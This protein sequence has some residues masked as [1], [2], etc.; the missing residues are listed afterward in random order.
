MLD[1]TV[2]EFGRRYGPLIGFLTV[3]LLAALLV[4]ATHDK[5]S[6][7]S[8]A[9]ARVDATS[10]DTATTALAG[11]EA[12]LPGGA[13]LA[14]GGL[15]PGSASGARGGNSGVT[16][17]PVGSHAAA[18]AA[19]R[20]EDGRQPG[21]SRYMPPCVDVFRGDNGGATAKGV[22]RDKIIVVRYVN[23]GD[24]ATRAAAAA[25]STK[26]VPSQADWERET[27][28]LMRYFNLHY[29]TYR[30]EVV[31]VTV[32]ASGTDDKS[33]RAD[34]VKIAQEIG[35]F[36]VFPGTGGADV[37]AFVEELA[38]RHVFC[39][40]CT[41]GYSRSFYRR[42]KGYVFATAPPL[43]EI[44]AHVAEYIGKRLAGKPARW[45]GEQSLAQRPRRFGLLWI[46][47]TFP[48]GGAPEPGQK[49]ARDFLVAEL[50]RYGV[51]LTRDVGYSYDIS[52][53]QEQA[54]NLI[55]QMKTANVTTLAWHGDPLSLIVFTREATRQAYFP[56]W[57]IV[58]GFAS[59]S[60]IF[61]RLY[62]QAQWRHAFGVTSGWV[63]P[64]SEAGAPGYREYHHA[65]P[66]A[67]ASEG[68]KATVVLHPTLELLFTG[69]QMAGPRLTV[70]TFQKGMY[71]YPETGGLIVAPLRYF[72]PDS[73]MALKDATEVFYDAGRSGADEVGNQGV[74]VQVFAEGGSRRTLGSWPRTDPK[75]FTRED[76]VVTTDDPPAGLPH[77]Q[78]GHT[79]PAD[80]R[81]RS[82]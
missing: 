42:T 48:G 55:V 15:A 16:S 82:C 24:A 79:H 26:I 46:N 2:R 73:P 61:G 34:A 38:A 75:V 37:P 59:D 27:A 56:E 43:E 13:A 58:S 49:Q 67:P 44:Y 52:R 30:R 21:I 11:T 62:D 78:N 40:G 8:A 51:P 47:N 70:E 72:R 18:P 4:P 36:A 80:Q 54:T 25:V 69:F 77:E 71:D 22:K 35:A 63:F 81:C 53:V 17:L 45:A 41:L 68:N 6:S 14:S 3:A 10:G 57:L 1:L 32:E 20:K 76:T 12:V 33:A 50:G 60:T 9:R 64:T 74:G 29:E 31:A 66:A 19:C 65:R 7:T 23:Y 5:R 39:M 28:A